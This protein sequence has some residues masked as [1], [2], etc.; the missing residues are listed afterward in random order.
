MTSHRTYTTP[1]G[2]TPHRYKY[3]S[4][5]GRTYK[6]RI[7][8][9]RVDPTA[10]K[11]AGIGWEGATPPHTRSLDVFQTSIRNTETSQPQH[12]KNRP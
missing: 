2:S 1:R 12:T 3:R 5:S 11:D 10:I 7:K 8:S 9:L 4:P 6:G